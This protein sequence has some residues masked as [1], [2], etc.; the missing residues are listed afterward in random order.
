MEAYV[1]IGNDS[2]LAL[3]QLI[4]EKK[5]SSVFILVDSNTRQFCLPLVQRQADLLISAPVIEIPAGEGGKGLANLEKIIT[6]LLKKNADRQSL[7]V[8]VGGGMVCDIGGFSASVFKRGINFIH[9]PT[10]LLAMVDAAIGGKTGINYLE[11]KNV[12]GTYAEPDAVFVYPHFLN[13]L[14]AREL[15]S[16]YAEI[17]KHILLSDSKWFHSLVGNPLNGFGESDLFDLIRHS[18]HF[19]KSITTEDFRENGLRKIL[20]FGHTLGHALESH[21][22]RGVR[23]LRHGEAIAAGMTGELFLSHKLAGFPQEDMYAAIVFLRNLF[24]HIQLKFVPDDL[25][26]YL[27]ADKKNSNEKIAFSLLSSPGHPAGVFYPSHDQVL[28]SINFLLLE[29]SSAPV[30]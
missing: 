29:F 23:P 12:I 3:N 26:P 11:K 15:K 2:L 20:N 17:F 7:L 19:K 30:Q 21:S 4:S 10:T 1:A 28:E 18:V 5:Y 9:I 24:N 16:G 27:H 14:S 8:N 22:M 6:V 13:T 25:F